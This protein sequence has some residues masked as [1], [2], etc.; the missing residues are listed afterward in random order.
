MEESYGIDLDMTLPQA[1]KRWQEFE[2]GDGATSSSSFFA[3]IDSTHTSIPTR[4]PGFAE[5]FTSVDGR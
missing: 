4:P 5:S 1:L 3:G 2:D